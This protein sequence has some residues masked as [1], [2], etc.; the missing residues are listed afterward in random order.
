VIPDDA[1]NAWANDAGTLELYRSRVRKQVE[2]MTCARQAAE[3]L[4]P[5][6][7]DGETLLDAGCGG[8]AY[9]WSF[10]DRGYRPEWHG[11]DYTPKMVELARGELAPR[12]GLAP[13]RFRLGAIETL[14][15]C[16]DTV[17]CFNVL[18]NSPHYGAPLERL[19]EHTRKRLLLR[20]AMGEELIVRYTPDPYL[21]E[22]ARHIRVYHNQYPLAEVRAF[23]EEHGFRVT[24]IRDERTGDG[25]ELVVDIPHA[26]RILLAE[27]V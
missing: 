21:D 1:A 3:V 8:G 11:L 5:L 10:A 16:F 6:L 23:I 18:T 13:E 25:T 24:P 9:F 19:L 2:E 20:E 12:A 4:G 17:L 27:R 7:G 26:W 22:G 14:D 15:E